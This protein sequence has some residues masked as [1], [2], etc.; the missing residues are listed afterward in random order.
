[1]RAM[2]TRFPKNVP[3][4]IILAND[5]IVGEILD[6][7]L[8]A[9]DQASGR[10]EIAQE[11]HDHVD[12]EAKAMKK[13][14]V[15]CQWFHG[16]SRRERPQQAFRFPPRWPCPMKNRCASLLAN[17]PRKISVATS[18]MACVSSTFGVKI[19]RCAKYSGA[20]RRNGLK[21]RA[22]KV[23]VIQRQPELG[24]VGE[25]LLHKTLHVSLFAIKR[26]WPG[27]GGMRS[28]HFEHPHSLAKGCI[29]C[30][31]RKQ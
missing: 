12:G 19:P 23:L 28:L 26:S 21:F 11:N 1:M 17:S 31:S 7:E 6:D 20:A 30:S 29:H 5:E 9:V 3:S 24:G 22:G 18:L 14:T 25:A 15:R 10:V 8:G 27:F 16:A 13:K 2:G 4:V